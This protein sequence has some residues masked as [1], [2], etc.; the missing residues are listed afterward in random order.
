MMWLI[1]VKMKVKP[2]KD[3]E[4]AKNTQGG[5]CT[6]LFFPDTRDILEQCEVMDEEHD[7]QENLDYLEIDGHKLGKGNTKVLMCTKNIYHRSTVKGGCAN[8]SST[9]LAVVDYDTE[10]TDRKETMFLH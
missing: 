3:V 8:I 1:L 10:S 2:I 7:A 4:E 6:A 5:F 9:L